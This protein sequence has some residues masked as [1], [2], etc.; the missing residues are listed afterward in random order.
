MFQQQ[1]K[2]EN[3]YNHPSRKDEGQDV[4]KTVDEIHLPFYNF[5]FFS[6]YMYIGSFIAP[7]SNV[8]LI[9]WKQKSIFLHRMW[10]TLNQYSKPYLQVKN[11]QKYFYEGVELSA[12]STSTQRCPGNSG[13]Y[14][15]AENINKHYSYWK[16]RRN[17]VFFFGNAVRLAG[18]QSPNQGSSPWLL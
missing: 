17:I 9:Y 12:A 18:S 1:V 15:K 11:Y 3:K 4:R 6:N 10:P 7:L 5:I 16:G 13:L 2:I 8:L 14:T